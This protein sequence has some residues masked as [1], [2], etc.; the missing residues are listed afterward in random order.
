[1]APGL[2]VCCQPKIRKDRSGLWA[3]AGIGH[4]G[5]GNDVGVGCADR[6]ERP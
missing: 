3:G 2:C 5:Q 6:S 4:S 1:M